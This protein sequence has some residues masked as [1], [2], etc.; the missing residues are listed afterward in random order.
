MNVKIEKL[1]VKMSELERIDSFNAIEWYLLREMEV[2]FLIIHIL[3]MI[4]CTRFYNF[5]I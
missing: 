2:T 1:M 3:L 4:L 5:L